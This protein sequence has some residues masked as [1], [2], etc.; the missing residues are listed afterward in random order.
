MKILIDTCNQPSVDKNISERKEEVEQLKV[1]ERSSNMRALWDPI[2][3]S[4]IPGWTQLQF[5]TNEALLL[6][7]IFHSQTEKIYVK[8]C[9]R[10]V[11]NKKELWCFPD[12]FVLQIYLIIHVVLCSCING[13]WMI[14]LLIRYTKCVSHV[15]MCKIVLLKIFANDPTPH[16][17]SYTVEH[18]T[19]QTRYRFPQNH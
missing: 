4:R 3:L 12:F 13:L 9:S 11:L 2:L 14:F 17:S 5:W 19:H 16:N 8:W 10:P 1:C 15:L 6:E 18:S 7:V